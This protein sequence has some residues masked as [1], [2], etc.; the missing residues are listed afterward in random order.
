MT[1]TL[2]HFR[3]YRLKSI[4]LLCFSSRLSPRRGRLGL[5]NL[6]GRPGR[7]WCYAIDRIYAFRCCP[8]RGQHRAELSAKRSS[9]WHSLTRYL[10]NSLTKLSRLRV[11]ASWQVCDASRSFLRSMI[12][13]IMLPEPFACAERCYCSRVTEGYPYRASE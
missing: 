5:E 3:C 6:D 2:S 8:R 9:P 10:R 12:R 11:N 4:E 1:L 7:P 13:R